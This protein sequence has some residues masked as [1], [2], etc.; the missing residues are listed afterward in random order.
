MKISLNGGMGHGND[1]LAEQKI[2]A[3]DLEACRR[4]DW[5]AGKRLSRNF[6]PLIHTLAEKRAGGDPHEAN[7]LAE[8]GKEGLLRAARKFKPSMDPSRFKIFALSHIESAMDTNA[9][10][11]WFARLL[12]KR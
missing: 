2:L 7:R 11:G 1:K 12:K 3:R 6:A 10:S 8:R 4:G 9:A 5:E